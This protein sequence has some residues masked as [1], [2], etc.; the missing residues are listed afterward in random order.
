MM[1]GM[2]EGLR[3]EHHGNRMLLSTSR[4]TATIEEL[5]PGFILGHY[6]G[7][8]AESM[9]RPIARLLDQRVGEGR[10]IAIAVNALNMGSYETGYR[11][12]WSDWMSKNRPHLDVV[13]ILFR[14]NL[15]RM[16]ISIVSMIINGMIQPF[17]DPHAFDRSVEETRRRFESV[18]VDTPA[19]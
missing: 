14:S 19:G 4:G 3:I 17:S 16:G 15:V 11:K 13:L 12:G 8:A 2:G 7:L 18:S 5:A 9:V 6:D 10:R 1:L